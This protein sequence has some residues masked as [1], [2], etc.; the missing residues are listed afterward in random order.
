MDGSTFSSIS[1][2]K[3]AD[4]VL[5]NS[6]RRKVKV[7]LLQLKHAVDCINLITPRRRRSSD[8][9][10]NLIGQI[11]VLASR[12]PLLP[13][14]QL[15]L[16]LPQFWTAEHV[17][18]WLQ[19][20]E[21]GIYVK[22]LPKIKSLQVTGKQ[23]LTAQRSF[24]SR[25]GLEDTDEFRNIRSHVFKLT[26]IFY[27]VEVNP[28]HWT[29]EHADEFIRTWP[30]RDVA[31]H[32]ERFAT[33]GMNGKDFSSLTEGFLL[34]LGISNITHRKK[35]LNLVKTFH[36][37]VGDKVMYSRYSARV[38]FIGF[39]RLPKEVGE[40]IGIELRSADARR[41]G[42]LGSRKFNDGSVKRHRYFS[43]KIGCGLFVRRSEI[44]ISRR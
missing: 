9:S 18:E 33:A 13:S 35:I 36:I 21:G 1:A 25:I 10:A 6:E 7:V 31:Q 43:A 26:S 30:D 16:P 29:T 44:K 12:E 8:M 20:L 27:P 23:L 39:P 15:H 24:F 11:H 19:D 38:K 40:W 42:R 34:D 17:S 4:L 3:L 2:R 32:A 28:E 22:Y 37:N 14:L 41:M 5:D